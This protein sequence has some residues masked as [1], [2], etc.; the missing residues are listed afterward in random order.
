MSE[1]KCKT[2]RWFR[3]PAAEMYDQ[4]IGTCHRRAP[5]TDHMPAVSEQGFCGEHEEPPRKANKGSRVCAI[6]QHTPS[7]ASPGYTLTYY[8]NVWVCSAAH[9]NAWGQ[10]H[11]TGEPPHLTRADAGE[12]VAD[13]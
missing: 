4:D 7:L 12:R 11:N 5:V 1:P 6:C 9:G 2:C 13:E 3:P 8:P 10:R